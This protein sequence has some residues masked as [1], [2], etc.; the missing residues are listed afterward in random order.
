M[1]INAPLVYSWS[2]PRSSTYGPLWDP[3][4][5]Q[6]PNQ[7]HAKL[8]MSHLLPLETIMVR[9]VFC[10]LQDWEKYYLDGTFGH[11]VMNTIHPICSSG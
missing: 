3:L 8:V 1:S 4:S 7:W 11:L 10:E 6:L 5:E 2:D 9:F